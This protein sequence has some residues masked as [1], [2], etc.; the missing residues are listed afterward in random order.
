MVG[1]VGNVSLFLAVSKEIVWDRSLS[2]RGAFIQPV[3]MGSC[4]TISHTCLPVQLVD[5]LDYGVIEGSKDA[6][7]MQTSFISVEVID[8][9]RLDWVVQIQ[10]GG[11]G[12]R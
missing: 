6:A 3:F 9:R 5:K 4:L 10:W 11:K 2:V 1:P 7:W 12:K 8:K